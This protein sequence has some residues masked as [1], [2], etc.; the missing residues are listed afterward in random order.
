MIKVFKIIKDVFQRLIIFS[1]LI[2][3]VFL[4][5]GC[6]RTM[7]KEEFF[8]PGYAP[9]P[10]GFIVNSFLGTTVPAA[11]RLINFNNA[12]VGKVGF[13]AS[14]S[15][16]VTWTITI[17]GDNG[18]VKTLTGMSDTIAKLE[19][20][21]SGGT[22]NHVQFNQGDSAKAVLTILGHDRTYTTPSFKIIQ[23]R[24]YNG[25]IYGDIRHILMDD[26]ESATTIR[27]LSGKFKDLGD[28]FV[29]S[30][31]SATH[32]IS[33]LYSYRMMG[34]DLNSNSWLAGINTE[35][36]DSAFKSAPFILTTDPNQ[37]YINM[38]V[39]GTGKANSAITVK[40]Y[41][42]D[43]EGSPYD[44]TVN[45]GYVY[46]IIVNWTGWK[47]VSIRYVDFKRAS[48][49]ALGGNGNGLKE[50]NKVVGAALQ[51]TSLP[52]FGK[53]VE[54]YFDFMMLTE[55]GAFNPE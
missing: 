15:H 11:G 45:D 46:D 39:Y 8:G 24:R 10:E 17:T 48:D 7:D 28:G 21:W 36:L 3:S 9:A 50:P 2:S 34:T 5:D 47:L 44:Q 4:F 25:N 27:S 23:S 35:P 19:T 1:L 49:P 22:S 55:N 30:G 51:L 32:K 33:G 13:E 38:Y 54:A 20:F 43:V 12:S 37:L 6:K 31:L 14:F 40:L 42:R 29:I 26:F 53:E 41:E 52:T 16:P 18:A